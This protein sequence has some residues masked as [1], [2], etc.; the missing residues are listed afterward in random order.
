MSKTKKCIVCKKDHSQEY[1]KYFCSKECE[2]KWDFK[3]QY[4]KIENSIICPYCEHDNGDDEDYIG[5]ESKLECCA[6]GEVFIV[7]AEVEITY[8]TNATD[9]FVANKMSEEKDENNE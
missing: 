4:E 6:C 8:T 9:E 5:F 2:K 3:N 7:E 1:D